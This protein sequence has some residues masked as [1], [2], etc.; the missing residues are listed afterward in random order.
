MKIKKIMLIVIL[1]IFTLIIYTIQKGGV[2]KFE[3]TYTI[4]NEKGENIPA[5]I[6]SRTITSTVNDK[7]E[8]VY[9]ILVFFED[10][11]NIKYYNPILFIP[12][13]KIV[14]I[15]DGGKKDF[16]FIGNNLFQ[17]SEKANQFTSLTNSLIF[18]G[19]PPIY[20]IS[21]KEKEIVFNSFEGLKK[22][23]TNLIL[24]IK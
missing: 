6:Y 16:L 12:K 5:K 1:I 7:E 24:K 4:S 3:N 20:E 14:G 2:L 15:V 10:D 23:G 19:T 18:D 17:K 11:K 9:E 22:Y 13:L 21:F 8:K